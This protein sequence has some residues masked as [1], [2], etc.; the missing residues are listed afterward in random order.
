MDIDV[1]VE[2]VKLKQENIPRMIFVML[3]YICPGHISTNNNI[4]F[5]LVI[6]VVTFDTKM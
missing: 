6:N 5:D 2:F 4:F 3:N 1:K